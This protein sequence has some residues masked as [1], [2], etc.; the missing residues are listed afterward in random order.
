MHPISAVTH[1][2]IRPSYLGQESQIQCI[3]I[4]IFHACK[5]ERKLL[6]FRCL[7]KSNSTDSAVVEAD[8]Y[9]WHE[10]STILICITWVTSVNSKHLQN[11]ASVQDLFPAHFFF[12]FLVLPL[13]LWEWF[14]LLWLIVLRK[15]F[16][17]IPNI[18]GL[19]LFTIP[20]LLDD[21]NQQIY[22]SKE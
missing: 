6:I 9:I 20:E 3:R 19:A 7:N 22:F 1:E 2:R 8:I 10:G 15:T 12:R 11:P 14:F 17:L 13:P 4:R 5:L 21:F 18:V 16:L